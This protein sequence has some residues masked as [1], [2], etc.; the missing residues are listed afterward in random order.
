MIFNTAIVFGKS[1][2]TLSNLRMYIF[3]HT[4]GLPGL[5]EWL[6]IRL[7]LTLVAIYNANLV[8]QEVT[9]IP[10]AKQTIVCIASLLFFF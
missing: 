5:L 6:L 7:I 3:E 8:S 4:D 2:M 9:N 1:V 10:I